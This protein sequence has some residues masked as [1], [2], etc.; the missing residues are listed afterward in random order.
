M[1][2]F[3]RCALEKSLNEL[4]GLGYIKTNYKSSMEKKEVLR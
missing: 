2:K 1:L 4:S 3:L